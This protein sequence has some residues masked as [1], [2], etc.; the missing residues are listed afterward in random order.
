MTKT[1][2]IAALSFALVCTGC[3]AGGN[4]AQKIATPSPAEKETAIPSST[5]ASSGSTKPAVQD[6][7]HATNTVAVL[8]DY[9]L[10]IPG[11]WE[12]KNPYYYAETGG[13]VSMLF[14]VSSVSDMKMDDTSIEEH[15]D[16]IIEGYF[17]AF[18]EYDLRS[19]KTE[20][21]N[22]ILMD[23]AVA[24]SSIEGQ[25]VFIEAYMFANPSDGALNNITFIESDNTEYTHRN[26][27]GLIVDSLK[28]QNGPG[29]ATEPIVSDEK[30][31]QE[32]PEETVEET[33]TPEPVS[34][35]EKPE[36]TPASVPDVLTIENNEDFAELVNASV[37]D[38][39]KQDAFYKKYSDK[40]IEFDCI[41]Y[42]LAENPDVKDTFDYVFVVENEAG[43]PGMML[44]CLRRAN[45]LNF[46]WDR[47]SRPEYLSVGSRLRMRASMTRGDD[48]DFIYLVPEKSWGR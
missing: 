40:L 22:D 2:G 41:V 36:K 16:S 42:S 8:G 38:L 18:G 19:I 25:E 7:D 45:F 11:T 31:E 12:D 43:D 15:R 35:E 30:P 1:I 47:K 46:R 44:L 33:A 3:S 21:I 9:T 4:N 17:D 26:D 39:D 23:H 10:E 24:R 29:E 32:I 20:R 14:I 34:S 5:P 28:L 27:V 37:L 6:F 13:R 48:P